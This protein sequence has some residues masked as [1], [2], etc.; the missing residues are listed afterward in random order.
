[1]DK[2]RCTIH[3]LAQDLVQVKRLAHTLANSLND[4]NRTIQGSVLNRCCGPFSEG[5][6]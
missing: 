2:T 6:E 3:D 5:Q 1:M 4:L